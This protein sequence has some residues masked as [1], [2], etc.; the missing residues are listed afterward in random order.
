M[1]MTNNFPHAEKAI[2]MTPCEPHELVRGQEQC[3]LERVGAVLDRQSV[4]LD[5]RNV[6]RIDAAGI[7]ALIALYR[8]AQKAGTQ[9]VITHAAPR[10]AGIL[11]LVG[12]DEILFHHDPEADRPRCNPVAA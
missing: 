9:F 7:A 12:L 10:V 4:T 11:A 3:L 5:L 2:V 6:T 1:A 8:L